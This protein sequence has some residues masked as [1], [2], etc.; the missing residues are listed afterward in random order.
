MP[1]HVPGQSRT[2]GSHERTA[3]RSHSHSG[4]LAPM[5][6]SGAPLEQQVIDDIVEPGDIPP[7]TVEGAALVDFSIPAAKFAA[8]IRAPEIVDTLPT[9]PDDAYPQGALVFYTI[10]EKLYRN[11][12]GSTWTV[13]VDGADILSNSVTAGKLAAGAIGAREIAVGAGSFAGG[14]LLKNG[15]FEFG[16]ASILAGYVYQ[17]TEDDL[18]G[19]TRRNSGE[20]VF[21]SISVNARTGSRIFTMK[22]NGSTAN[23]GVYQN[24]PVVAGRRYRLSAWSWK[25][26]AGGVTPK[27][28]VTTF[29][30]TMTPVV[31]DVINLA[32]PTTTTPTFVS[33]SYLV[34]TDG[35]VSYLRVEF[36]ANGTPADTEVF[37]WDDVVLM[38]LPDNVVGGGGDVLIDEDGI[39]ISNGKLVFQDEFGTSV[40]SGSGFAGPW[41][42]FIRS[43]VYNNAFAASVAGTNIFASGSPSVA[44]PYWV[45]VQTGSPSSGAITPVLDTSVGSK[46]HL[47]M[48]ITGTSGQ[49]SDEVM[50]EQLIPL[51]HNY[52]TGGSVYVAAVYRPVTTNASMQMKMAAQ[53]VEADGVTTV[54]SEYTELK[55]IGT[56][57]LAAV[58]AYVPQEATA[59]YVRMRISLLRSSAGTGTSGSVKLYVTLR[60]VTES[61]L[62]LQSRHDNTAPAM[63]YT[64]PVS[65]ETE[66]VMS[67]EVGTASA[68][69]V[70]SGDHKVRIN[71]DLDIGY[72]NITS[73]PLTGEDTSFVITGGGSATYT[74]KYCRYVKIGRLVVFQLGW[75][76]NAAGSGTTNLEI[77]SQDTGLP[78][79]ASA[80]A[81]VGDRGGTGVTRLIARC[82]NGTNELTFTTFALVSAPTTAL[83]GSDLAAGASWNFMGSYIAAS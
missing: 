9:L 62:Y 57:D 67:A 19:W 48:E 30:E 38:E 23:P 50:I 71:G 70:R 55:T 36:L 6:Y 20:S 68:I 4:Y 60:R 80:F 54:G 47:L 12:D 44:L 65:G 31:Y 33:G 39:T 77:T 69:A 1:I 16:S 24:V 66:L 81:I 49:A 63:V 29:D 25:G 45:G 46:R 40:L 53:C 14:N 78:K 75:V 56:T 52:A 76:V 22:G 72:G 7:G 5:E 34:P 83:N 3:R 18:L 17:P 37:A 41:D 2:R 27:L 15:S 21:Y 42:D 59:A 79:A 32:G 13:A 28:R 11:S 82:V 64:V 8:T 51:T 10:D 26:A 73:L 61:V 74:S 58:Q 35:S 43:G